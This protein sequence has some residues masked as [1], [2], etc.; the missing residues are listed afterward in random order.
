[1]NPVGVIPNQ[2][3][4]NAHQ[5]QIAAGKVRNQLQPVADIAPHQV[6]EIPGRHQ[7]NAARTIGEI[8]RVGQA[9]L[10]ELTDQFDL[11]GSEFFIGSARR[12][13]LDADDKFPR[14][15]FLRKSTV[16]NF[17]RI[18]YRWLRWRDE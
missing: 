3:A 11:A 7:R 5:V 12:K 6:D 1:M 17:F 13:H 4:L 9:A 18:A 2:P 15:K 16:V 14:F 8:H 10:G